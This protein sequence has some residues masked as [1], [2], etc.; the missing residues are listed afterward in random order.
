MCQR[1]QPSIPMKNPAPSP[2]PL[3][4]DRTSRSAQRT[5]EPDR[6]TDDAPRAKF[7]SPIARS[8]ECPRISIII[9]ALNECEGIQEVLRSIPRDKL[10]REGYEVEVVVVDGGSVDGTP[11]IAQMAGAKVIHEPRPG[12]GQ[13]IR[14]GFQHSSGDVL[15]TLDADGTYPAEEIPKLVRLILSEGVD[16]VTTNRFALIERGA[17][18]SRNRFGNWALTTA[19]RLLFGIRLSDSQ[20]GMWAFRRDL[21]TKLRLHANTPFSQELKVEAIHRARAAWR[22]VPIVYRPRMGRA[23]LGNWRVGIENLVHLLAKRF[24]LGQW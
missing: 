24:S 10:S 1:W 7:D 14:T 3:P 19:T 12:Y 11:E 21:L 18:S 15:V 23:K 17:M 9:P 6:V 5:A 2:S 4:L 8:A 16:F 22:E 20:S 13:A